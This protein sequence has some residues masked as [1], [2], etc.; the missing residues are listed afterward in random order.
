MPPDIVVKKVMITKRRRIQLFGDSQILQIE[1]Q[2]S[3]EEIMEFTKKKP[4]KTL[5][6]LILLIF[7]CIMI[8]LVLKHYEDWIANI[9]AIF[10]VVI[11]II[12]LRL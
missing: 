8:I 4:K 1:S 10:G 2:I 12:S 7:G 11:A 6:G 5:I 3:N 9:C